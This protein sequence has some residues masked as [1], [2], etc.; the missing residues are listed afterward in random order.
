MKVCSGQSVLDGI[1][2]GKLFLY[3]KKEYAN[4]SEHTDDPAGDVLRFQQA[5]SAAKEQLEELHRTALSQTGESQASIFEAQKMILE[6]EEFLRNVTNLIWEKQLT[7]ESAVISVGEWFA[8]IFEKLEDF[9]LKERAA[10]VRDVSGRIRKLLVRDPESV[11]RLQEPVILLTD[12]L[13]PGQTMNLDKSRILAFV[14]RRGSNTSHTAILA[15]SLQIPALVGAE[16]E[17]DERYHGCMAVVDGLTG[18]LLIDPDE[19][20]LAAM[21]KQQKLL[22]KE[23]QEWMEQGISGKEVF[24][25][26]KKIHIC[27]NIQSPSEAAEALACHADGIGLFRSE[28]LYLDR[29]EYPGEEEQYL[30]YREVVAAMQ[31]KRVI[32]RTLDI[33]A[34]KQADYFMLPAEENPAM[35]Y[36]AVRICLDRPEMFVTQL[37]AILRAGAHGNA[38]VM[39]PMITSVRELEC[40][41]EMLE[42]ARKELEQE[43]K[44][45]GPL[46][47]GV[48]IETPA[49]VMISDQ[50]AEKVD[51]FSIGTN[52]LTQYTL[53]IDRCNPRLE[54]FYDAHHPALLR[55]IRMTAES[56]AKQ[57]IRVAI[58]GE[59]ASDP[60]MTGIL[61]DMGI[62]ELSMAA[63]AIGRTKVQLFC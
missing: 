19:E 23:R 62:D 4:R 27:A 16:V 26:G 48:M 60:A 58:C 46:Q 51:F 18:R 57:G 25:N 20:T 54:R 24:R 63:A 36:R 49:A 9:Y 34:D 12:D 10:D 41:K 33:G 14:T 53:A 22:E 7:A 47:I 17:L 40:C 31:G 45:Y 52:D 44:E 21:K 29:T 61:L 2:I 15:R 43:G 59:L 28:F 39:F 3:E 50:L 42:T 32:I 13:T 55:M 6:D 35:G 56:A 38:G 8:G 1:A 5:V 11:S 30:A 37:K